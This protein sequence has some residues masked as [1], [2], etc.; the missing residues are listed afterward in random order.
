MN[1]ALETNAPFV[2]RAGTARYVRGLLTGLHQIT[3]P[4]VNWFELAWPVENLD[5]RQPRR[6]W[7]TIYREMVWSRTTAVRE[8]AKR[9]PDVIH[10]TGELNI[11]PPARI[12]VVRTLLDCSAIRYPERFRR[13]QRNRGPSRLRCIPS[14]DRVICISRFTA[15]EGIRWLGLDPKKIDVVH[16]GSDFGEAGTCR[17]EKQP[18]FRLPSIFFLFIGSLE[19]GKNLALLRE[20]Y[21]LAEQHGIDLPPLVVIG[22]RPEGLSYEGAAPSNWQLVGWQPDEV[23]LYCLRRAMAFV[24][25]TKYEGFGLP[26]LEA[27]SVGCP[28]ICSPV[29]SL[30]EIGGDAVKYCEQTADAYLEAMSEICRGDHLR[31][32]L[33]E[34]GQK[35]ARK[36]SWRQCAEETI[37]SYRKSL[38][39]Y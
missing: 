15:D 35:Q 23:L 36:F 39:K 10:L 9:H 11:I 16:L 21:L 31:N 26:L 12:P 20:T 2:T 24:F 18:S 6:A 4:D 37:D 38:G 27:M 22:V 32:Q 14:A 33:S 28:A 30:P 7:R 8:L 5:Y 1:I 29:A 34:L 19:P 17:N 13:W 25:P 3:R